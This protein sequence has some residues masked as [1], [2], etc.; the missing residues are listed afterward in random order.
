[1]NRVLAIVVAVIAA[2][3]LASCDFLDSILGVNIF[4]ARY[5]LSADEAANMSVDELSTEADNPGFFE[6]VAEDPALED[7]ILA[8]VDDVIADPGST[9]AEVEAAAILGAEVLIYGS[10]AG[11]LINNAASE[12]PYLMDTPP[13]SG[14]SIRDFVSSIIPPSLYVDGVLDR[15]AFTLMVDDLLAS[16]TYFETIGTLLEANGG[17]YL[18]PEANAGEIAQNALVAAMVNAVT[19]SATWLVLNPGGSLGDYLFDLLTDETT[20]PPD[21]YLPPDSETGYLYWIL[22][23]AGMGDI[24]LRA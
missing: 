14:E 10:P 23:A 22:E 1:M 7:E 21:S 12:L 11:E 18:D 2:L 17:D 19:P 24:N 16:L 5:E 9:D 8:E 13:D 15:A 6:A 4:E 3:S 20:D